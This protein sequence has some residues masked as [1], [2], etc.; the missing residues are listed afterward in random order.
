[1][2]DVQAETNPQVLKLNSEIMKLVD[3]VEIAGE[4]GNIDSAQVSPPCPSRLLIPRIGTHDS[5]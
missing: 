3:Q 5:R 1:M 2:R 4:A